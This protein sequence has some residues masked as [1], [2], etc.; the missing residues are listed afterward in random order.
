MIV[1]GKI[2]LVTGAASGIGNAVA[3]R[4][5]EAGARKVGVVD[6]TD[7][8]V[9]AAEQINR[10]A[11]NDVAIPFQGDVTDSS[12]RQQVYSDLKDHDPVRICVP[13]AGI[14][15]DAMAV[16]LNKENGKAE[17]YDEDRFRQVLEVNLMHP[18]YWTMQM[19]AGIAEHR[20]ASDSGKWSAAEDIQGCS[21]IIGSVSSRGN[22]G[23]VSYSSAKSGLNAASKT[24]NVEGSFYGIQTKI[25]HP[26]FVQTPM[27]DQLPDGLFEDHL[28]KLVPIDR[29]IQP[30]E[31]ANTV[32]A[33]I[34]NPIISGP[35][36]ADGGLPPMT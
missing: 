13:A 2:A 19:I 3:E 22:R 34:E 27:V 8:V 10:S 36:W 15:R 24:L 11:D 12:F 26:G 5:V 25:I 20:A 28:R 7:S 23:Q 4:L 33:M 9:A 14:L 30:A 29:L 17:L 32:V 1:Q 16:K 35:V 18:T 6:L 21:V 31:I